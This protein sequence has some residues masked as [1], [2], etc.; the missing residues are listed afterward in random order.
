[1]CVPASDM[2]RRTV[3][4][5]DELLIPMKI[6]PNPNYEAIS[7]SIGMFIRYMLLNFI[8]KLSLLYILLVRNIYMI[9]TNKLVS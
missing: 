5:F 2:A 9:T 8:I 4:P 1:M 7:L 6:E 3:N